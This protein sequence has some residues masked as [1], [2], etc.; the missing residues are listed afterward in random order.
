MAREDV[1]VN[2]AS[3]PGLLPRMLDAADRFQTRPSDQAMR[4][5]EE[6]MGVEPLF[7][8]GFAAG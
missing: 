1:F 2:S 5:H 6:R 4:A 7:L 8:R 3:D